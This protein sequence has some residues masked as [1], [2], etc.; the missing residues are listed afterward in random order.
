MISRG[1]STRV[2]EGV[3]VCLAQ[4]ESEN[5]ARPP[6]PYVCQVKIS[7]FLYGIR[8]FPWLFCLAT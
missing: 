1:T 6:L 7:G 8:V 4:L 3:A 5:G 2:S